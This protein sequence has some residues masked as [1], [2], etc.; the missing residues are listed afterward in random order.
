MAGALVVFVL[1]PTSR[2][3]GYDHDSPWQR[4]QMTFWHA[5]ASGILL[6]MSLKAMSIEP[7]RS[8]VYFVF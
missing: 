5:G 6:W 2:Y 3:A 4:L 1:K 8:F 7:S